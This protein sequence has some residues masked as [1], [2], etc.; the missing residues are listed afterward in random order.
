MPT[1]PPPVASEP[2]VI[3]TRALSR[4]FGR[5]PAVS[6]LN[7]TVPAGS[8]YGFLGPNGAGKTTTIRMLLGLIR[9][10]RGDVSIFGLGLREHR[11][12]ILGRIGSLVEAPAIYPH[13]TGRENLEVIARL[14]GIR[15]SRID[16][17]LRLVDLS[18]A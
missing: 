12:G 6:D 17:A 9:P 5:S 4:S 10:S 7:L 8:L 3:V 1:A 15:R 18:E 2:P 14:V 11:K 13:L 16:E